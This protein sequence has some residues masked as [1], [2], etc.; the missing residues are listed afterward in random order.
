MNFINIIVVNNFRIKIISF[1]YTRNNLFR[2]YFVNDLRFDGTS[3]T[4]YVYNSCH[5]VNN[6]RF[7]EHIITV[8]RLPT[9]QVKQHEMLLSVVNSLR[10]YTTKRI[11]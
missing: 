9:R 2:W 3:I 6:L 5:F 1:R 4:I 11:G 10:I 7:A 8:T